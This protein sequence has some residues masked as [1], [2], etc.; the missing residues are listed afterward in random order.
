MGKSRKDTKEKSDHKFE[1]K[2]RFY[3]TVRDTVATLNAK[4]S[5]T[6][7]KNLRRR[8]K[9]L[10]AYDLTT[11]SEFLPELK[12]PQKPKEVPEIKLNCK[13]R[14]Q[15][16]LKEGKQLSTVL[17]HP[18]FLSDPLGS[19]HQHLESTQPPQEENKKKAIKDGGKK[20]KRKN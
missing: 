16:I 18:A 8:Q 7:K 1:K 20:T 12:D 15:L 19:I 3:A 10:K 13:S 6:K 2:I 9:K 5:I 11:L 14:K 4:K 17:N